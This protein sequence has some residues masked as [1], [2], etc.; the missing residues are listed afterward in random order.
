LALDV[1][2]VPMV[3]AVAGLLVAIFLVVVGAR[4]LRSAVRVLL[5]ASVPASTL[6]TIRQVAVADPAVR[7][8]I[9]VDARNSGAFVFVHLAVEPEAGDLTEAEAAGRDLADRIRR[10]V[11]SVDSVA[12][13]FAAAEGDRRLAIPIDGA[14]RPVAVPGDA[15]GLALVTVGNEATGRPETVPNPGAEIGPDAGVYLAV[16]AGRR[17]V[18]ALVVP[19]QPKDADML[20]TLA[21][22]GVS[23]TVAADAADV[24]AATDAVRRRLPP[25]GSG[26]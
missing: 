13:E 7:R 2:G 19:A 21:A 6:S 12:I 20:D 5:D 26:T 23:V 9:G 4:M 18:D 25:S 22:Y 11:T 1:A 24:G 10:T 8:V 15:I 16:A 17:G 14:G 3:D